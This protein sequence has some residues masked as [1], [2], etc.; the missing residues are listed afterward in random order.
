[1]GILDRIHSRRG[2]LPA[3]QDSSLPGQHVR[4]VQG[5]EG[6]CDICNESMPP[7]GGIVTAEGM[8]RL[9]KS[10]FDPYAEPSPAMNRMLDLFE[11]EGIPRSAEMYRVRMRMLRKEMGGFALCPKCFGRAQEYAMRVGL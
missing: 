10:G 3:K 8:K 2:D 7:S 5:F 4:P 1:M 6:L 11:K 9:V